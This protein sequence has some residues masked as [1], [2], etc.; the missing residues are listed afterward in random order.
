[1]QGRP[2]PPT[3]TLA[4]C[5][6]LGHRR[7]R[8]ALRAQTPIRPTSMIGGSGSPQPVVTSYDYPEYQHYARQAVYLNLA[9]SFGAPTSPTLCAQP[10]SG[11]GRA[12]THAPGAP[13]RSNDHR[14]G[15]AGDGAGPG[16]GAGAAV[17]GE[18]KRQISLFQLIVRS[19]P[20]PAPDPELSEESVA[21]RGQWKRLVQQRRR[22]LLQRRRLVQ[23]RRQRRLMPGLPLLPLLPTPRH[24]RR[25]HPMRRRQHLPPRRQHPPPRLPPRSHS[26]RRAAVSRPPTGALSCSSLKR[27]SRRGMMEGPDGPT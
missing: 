3:R 24:Q 5:T 15:C 12:S 13:G 10:L 22:L 23:K 7:R 18:E 9:S 14:A 17:V 6:F 27:S 4:G 16:A 2:K 20:A 11:D 26:P 21:K 19:L 8:P 25:R 1:M